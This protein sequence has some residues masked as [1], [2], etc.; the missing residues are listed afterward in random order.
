MSITY[1]DASP[2]DLPA[3]KALLAEARL[4]TADVGS[5]HQHFRVATRDGVV[6][7][8]AGLELY[9]PSSALLRSLA[10]YPA[11]QGTGI[12]KALYGQVMREARSRHVVNVYL[13]T[14]TAEKFFSNAGFRQIA[15]EEVPLA[16]RR[17]AEFGALCPASAVCM[18]LRLD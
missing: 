7:G 14:T 4:P 6:A 3:I 16:V 11:L 13:L 12:G 18:G 15:R 5:D 8:C 17:S 10:V 9:P 2:E 1:R